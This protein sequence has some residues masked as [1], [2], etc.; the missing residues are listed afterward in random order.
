MANQKSGGDRKQGMGQANQERD[1]TRRT[2]RQQQAQ[3]DQ[4]PDT[5]KGGQQ[6]DRDKQD[7]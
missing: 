1:T 5:R 3:R 2:D 6:G 4:Q 7:R